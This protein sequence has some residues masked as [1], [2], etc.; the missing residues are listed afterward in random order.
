MVNKTLY[1][2]RNNKSKSGVCD[3]SNV[4]K[5]KKRSRVKIKKK[6]SLHASVWNLQ[7]YKSAVLLLT[8][9]K[10]EMKKRIPADEAWVFAFFVAFISNHSSAPL[11]LLYH[12]LKNWTTCRCAHVDFKA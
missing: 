2:R 3:S 5:N 7:R 8:F 10:E 11:L 6:K 12:S 9:D 1:T 4:N